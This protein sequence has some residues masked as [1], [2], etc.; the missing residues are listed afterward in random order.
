MT[1]SGKFFE[2]EGEAADDERDDSA[3]DRIDEET[4][5]EKG[6]E[7]E[8][9]EKP[10][11]ASPNQ[12]PGKTVRI[13]ENGAKLNGDNVGEVTF[14]VVF[15]NLITL[16]FRFEHLHTFTHIYALAQLK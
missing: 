6:D 14:D 7:K 9:K 16:L 15:T 8:E 10:I 13:K 11:S 4:E 3:I 2:V 12:S 1:G 5:N